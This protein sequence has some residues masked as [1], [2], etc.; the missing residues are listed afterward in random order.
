MKHSKS[1]RAQ[2]L[3]ECWLDY[4][5]ILRRRIWWLLGGGLL[6]GV[7]GFSTSLFLSRVYLSRAVIERS[8]SSG[9]GMLTSELF[10]DKELEEIVRRENLDA[11]P[12]IGSVRKAIAFVRAHA[13][14]SPINS[15]SFL[16]TYSD[17][18]RDVAQRV[19]E[20]LVALLIRKEASRPN[21]P[22]TDGETR[23]RQSTDAAARASANESRTQAS[24]FRV[25]EPPTVSWEPAGPEQVKFTVMGFLLGIMLGVGGTIAGV[26]LDDRIRR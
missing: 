3:K 23:E 24:A 7:I 14:I 25:L 21:P 2:R 10:T 19:S 8:E 15:R 12:E 17:R 20:A 6:L 4:S 9:A 18:D 11:N 13:E 5:E 26:A 1:R 22:E 16:V